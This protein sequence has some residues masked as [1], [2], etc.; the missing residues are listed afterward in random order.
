M[1]RFFVHSLGIL[2][3][4]ALAVT[5][6][7]SAQ[8]QAAATMTM[9][10]VQQLIARGQPADHARLSAHFSTLANQYAAEA[11]RHAAMRPA[12]AGNT[13]LAAMATSQ[14][15]H[16][17]QLAT[18]NDQSAALLRE[19][20]DHHRRE[21]A[22]AASVPPAGSERFQ[23]ARVPSDAEL[24]KLA[25]SASSAADHGA[26][27]TYFSN[28]ADRYAREAKESAAFAGTWRGMTRNPAAAAQA[29]RWERLARQQSEEAAEARAAAAMH[30]DHAGAA[31]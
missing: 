13:K 20:A 1:K 6:E 3:A 24:T 23:G 21:A 15:A 12:F 28:A 30:R 7:L 29:E 27:A 17:Q 9:T 14:A 4:A 11:K 26:L 2:T 16:C 22:G 25:A 19:L 10:E 8:G 18:R 31:K 5:P